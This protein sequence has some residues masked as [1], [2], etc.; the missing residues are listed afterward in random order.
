VPRRTIIVDPLFGQRL[1]ALRGGRSYRDVGRLTGYSGAYI[2]QLAA[3]RR[4]PT[5]ESAKVI[6]TALNAGGALAGLVTS[7]GQDQV[8][9]ADGL[10]FAGDWRV[11]VES[12]TDLWRWSARRRELLHTATFTATAFLPA[13]MRWLAAPADETPVGHGDRLVGPPEL[14]TVRQVT[15]TFRSL[16]NRYGGGHV[17]APLAR[18]L[19]AEV[20]PLL[21]D[22][23]Y[24]PATGSALF[25]AAAETTRL[26]GWAAYDSGLHGVAQRY[27][28]QALRLALAA[29]DRPLGAEILAAMSHQ[30]A[31]LGA[32]TEAVDLARAAGRAATDAGVDAIRAEAAVLEAQGHAVAGEEAT[33]ARALD[34]AEKTLDRAERDQ[35]PQWLGYF[36]EAYL[37]AKFGHCFA[38]LGRGDLA[39]RF[40]ARS[41][42]MDGRHYARGRQFNLALLATAHAQSGEVEQAAAVGGEA[43]EAAAGLR[44][45]RAADYIAD[46]A[47]RLAQHVGLP[48]VREFADRAQPVLAGATAGRLPSQRGRPAVR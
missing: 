9:L 32:S 2:Q 23:R 20:A 6:D 31:Y 48:A 4:R 16:D 47:E 8:E 37:A 10:G 11:G 39:Q 40:A 29:G 30:A 22:G 43:L 46:V 28:V 24:D 34:A 18:F 15:A 3:G 33:C 45:A 25:S 27:L 36:D 42:D 5:P 38:A 41:L 7:G 21:R 17:Y 1:D 14:D 35:D 44:S 13:A 12:A 19:D 26:T